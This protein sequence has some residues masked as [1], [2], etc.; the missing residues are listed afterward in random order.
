[1]EETIVKFKQSAN[2]GDLI[3]MLPGIRQ[4]TIEVKRK[5]VIYQRLNVVGVGTADSVH[6]FKNEMEQPV[7]MNKYMFDMVRPLILEQDYIE[8]FLVF[9]GGEVDVDL[10]KIRLENFTNQPKG[11][12]NRWPFYVFPQMSCDL[13]KAWLKF[14][15]PIIECQTNFGS[16]ILAETIIINFTVRYR[17]TMVHYFFLKEH[18]SKI[19]FAGLESEYELFKKDYALNIPLLIIKDFSELARVISNC[20]FFIGNQSMAFQ[21]AEG[22]KH[23]R[24]L[25]IFPGMPN[26]IPIG[27]NAYDA[28]HQGAIEYYFNKLLKL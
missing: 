14:P 11:Q 27:E 4:F 5:A 17:Q 19:V 21:I 8:D 18:E 16:R 1:M 3:S 25:E 7:C 15:F 23:P 6:P 2:V 20:K 10:D 28:Y 9:T 13:S 12:I 26:V 22:L 24:L